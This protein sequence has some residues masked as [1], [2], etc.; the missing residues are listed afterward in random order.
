L[1]SLRAAILIF[2]KRGTEEPAQRSQVAEVGKLL[3]ENV[4]QC[5]ATFS[6]VLSL[7]RKRGQLQKS[8]EEVQELGIFLFAN[9]SA[10]RTLA[11]T[12]SKEEVLNAV[13]KHAL[14]ALGISKR[15][16]LK[17]VEVSLFERKDYEQPKDR[18]HCAFSSQA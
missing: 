8:P 1:S 4:E 18:F 3:R 14:A 5:Q 2:A 6:Q 12:G 15:N 17:Q 13:A 11:K 10:I 7:A 16:S 9:L